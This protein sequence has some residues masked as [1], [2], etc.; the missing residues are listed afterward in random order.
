M[1]YSEKQKPETS[2]ESNDGIWELEQWNDGMMEYWE[3]TKNSEQW[4]DGI[5]EF[6]EQQEL[7]VSFPLNRL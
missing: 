5:V 6:W 2:E 1:E 7:K 3:M 4:N